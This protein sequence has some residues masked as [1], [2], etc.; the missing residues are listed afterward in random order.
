MLPAALRKNAFHEY[1][2]HNKVAGCGTVTV[3]VRP[4]R[5][6]LIYDSAMAF[7]HLWDI[8]HGFDLLQT[9]TGWFISKLA[10]TISP[11][12]GVKGAW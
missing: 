7:L 5:P 9:L 10:D 2:I 12:V 1:Q 4:V 11:W 6:H 3:T 8:F